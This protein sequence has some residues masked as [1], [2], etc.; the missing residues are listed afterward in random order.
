MLNASGT[1]DPDQTN[2]SLT[3]EWDLDYDGMT[4]DLDATGMHPTFS[5]GELDGQT[6]RTV[7]VRVTDQ[8]GLAS[9]NTALIEIENV[10]PTADI[11]GP[12]YAGVPGQTLAFTL[13]ALDPCIADQ[14][15]GFTYSI[16][17][18]DTK[19]ETVTGLTGK[20]VFDITGLNDGESREAK[21]T[22]TAPDGSKKEFTVKVLLLTP[23]E[24]EFFRN[25]GIL[26]YVLRQLAGKKAA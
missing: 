19:V 15:A 4:F 21:V 1:T 8:G 6:S 2:G 13:S 10:A 23:K 20:E 22:A 16:N 3:Y 5:A 18:G 11:S 12:A 25:G 24:R 14:E 17:W 26:Q 7:A 9:T